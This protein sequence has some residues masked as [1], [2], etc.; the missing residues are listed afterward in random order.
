MATT[1]RWYFLRCSRMAVVLP[2][3]DLNV[4]LQCMQ[5]VR[6]ETE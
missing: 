3:A 6:L 1:A 4:M 2:E 5:I